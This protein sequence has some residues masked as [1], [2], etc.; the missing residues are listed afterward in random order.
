MEKCKGNGG[1]HTRIIRTREAERRGRE[2][3]H[4]MPKFLRDLKI[5]VANLGGG[6]WLSSGEDEQVAPCGGTRVGG[7]DQSITK[8]RGSNNTDEKRKRKEGSPEEGSCDQTL[9]STSWKITKG[10][11]QHQKSG[12]TKVLAGREEN[13]GRN[14]AQ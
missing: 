10:V 14:S 11:N 9:S 3:G 13:D 1:P 12:G 4:L 7:A 8:M 6:G 2:G 5:N